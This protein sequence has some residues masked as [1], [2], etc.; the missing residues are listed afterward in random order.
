M[1]LLSFLPALQAYLFSVP[2]HHWIVM[3]SLS[4]ALT[5]LLFLRK[6]NTVYGCIAFG[7]TILILLFLLD[8][9][10]GIR[11]DG[12][13]MAKSSIN[14][15]AEY[16]RLIHGSE[17]LRVL[18]LFNVSVF[19]PFGFFLMEFLTETNQIIIK[20]RIKYTVLGGFGLSLL[21]ECL[22]LFLKVGFFEFTDLF[23]NTIGTIVGASLSLI[24][25]RRAL[26]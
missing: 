4:L 14:L 26:T 6:K 22:Q 12:M 25:H 24:I 9:A 13:R 19:I 20:R 2:A 17:R 21:I 11:L 1:S 18:M 10:V 23:L 3:I 8:V 15:N 7:F 16:N 5:L